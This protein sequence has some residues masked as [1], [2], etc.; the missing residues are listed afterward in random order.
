MVD[1]F[2]F[3]FIYYKSG[4]C[5]PRIL[6]GMG[7]CTLRRMNTKETPLLCLSFK[8]MILTVWLLDTPLQR[9]LC[10]PPYLQEEGA[11]VEGSRGLHGSPRCPSS[12]WWL[13]TSVDHREEE[14]PATLPA[15]FSLAPQ[16]CNWLHKVLLLPTFGWLWLAPLSLCCIS[17][18]VS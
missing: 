5:D 11:R 10:H 1:F 8:R 17:T 3:H 9:Y 14:D 7:L 13:P 12:P 2:F 15:S 4:R 16:S 6:S 18:R